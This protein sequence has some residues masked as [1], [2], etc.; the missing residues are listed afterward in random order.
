MRAAIY[1][2]V[3]RF[4][5]GL[6]WLRFGNRLKLAGGVFALALIGGGWLVA[7]R[8]PPEG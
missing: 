2:R 5:L 1:E 6:V 8:E 4:I 7:R 3:G